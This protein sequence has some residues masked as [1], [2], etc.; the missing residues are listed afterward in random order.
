MHAEL[1]GN[2]LQA[3]ASKLQPAFTPF[4]YIRRLSKAECS[5]SLTSWQ[6]REESAGEQDWWLTVFF[7]SGLSWFGTALQP[8]ASH[9][10]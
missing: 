3:F 2:E 9:T 5:P 4:C 1:V 8:R 10:C 6:T 7:L